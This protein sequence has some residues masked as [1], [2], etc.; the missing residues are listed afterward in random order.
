[1]FSL[2]IVVNCIVFRRHS[3]SADRPTPPEINFKQEEDYEGGSGGGGT[4]AGIY[5]RDVAAEVVDN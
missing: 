5:K 4:G 3:L 1:M 2:Q